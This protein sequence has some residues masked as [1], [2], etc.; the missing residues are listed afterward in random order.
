MNWKTKADFR[1]RRHLRLRK[2]VQGTADRPRMSV[3]VSNKHLYVQFIDDLAAR[4]LA[5][6]STLVEGSSAK[7]SAGVE[8]ARK[9]GALSA[10]VAKKQ[11]IQSVV[12]DRGGFAYRGRVKVLA[13]A[14]REA[15]LQF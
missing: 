5:A 10:E 2:K 8:T 12:F 14:A 11:G 7:G 15:G 6:A 4:T 1:K 13:E 3:F 9:L